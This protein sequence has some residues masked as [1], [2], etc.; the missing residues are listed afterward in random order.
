MKEK[1]YE[2]KMHAR[3]GEDRITA[4]GA[5]DRERC[6]GSGSEQHRSLTVFEKRTGLDP[7]PS[8]D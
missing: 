8:V 6:I 3:W 1:S 4:A 5:S 7:Y 2:S